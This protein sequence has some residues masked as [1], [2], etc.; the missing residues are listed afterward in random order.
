MSA[1]ITTTAGAGI[2]SAPAID[3]AAWLGMVCDGFRARACASGQARAAHAVIQEAQTAAREDMAADDAVLLAAIG[4]G[5]ERAF[6]AFM[7]RH[8]DAIHAFAFRFTGRAAD[9][10]DIA[11]ETFLRVW[12]K[13]GGWTPGAAKPATWLHT[14]ATNLC[15][16]HARRMKLRSW[17][18]FSGDLDPPD[19]A[20]APDTQVADREELSRVNAAIAKLPARQRAAL[21]LSVMGGH[22]NGEI[23][24]ILK[25]STGAVEQA[26]FRA[27]KTLRERF[28]DR[29]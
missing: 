25:T 8:L 11:Q 13:A 28:D 15:I 14:I 17:L 23:A 12:R 26:L 1:T 22:A 3:L 2:F 21:V 20:P 7:S 5:D 27:R 24:D 9:A 29:T 4:S 19:T 16:D 10:Q 6:N 18:P